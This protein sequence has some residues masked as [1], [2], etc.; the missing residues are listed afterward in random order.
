M[1]SKPYLECQIQQDGHVSKIIVF[2]SPNFNDNFNRAGVRLLEMVLLLGGVTL[3]HSSI[4]LESELQDHIY[5]ER[6]H[7]EVSVIRKGIFESIP[8]SVRDADNN[9]L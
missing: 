5:S 6:L 7:E 9:I 8:K 3:A 2:L 4:Y 1:V